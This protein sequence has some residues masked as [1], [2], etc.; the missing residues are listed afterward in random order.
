MAGR[1]TGMRSC[2]KAM[3][4][5]RRGLCRQARKSASAAMTSRT[6]ASKLPGRGWLEKPRR[7]I[8]RTCLGALSASASPVRTAAGSTS[9]SRGRRRDG[10]CS[11]R[12]Q[13]TRSSSATSAAVP[14]NC[15]RIRKAHESRSP[16]STLPFGRIILERLQ[17]EPDG[18]GP[19]RATASIFPAAGWNGAGRWRARGFPPRRDRSFARPAW[20]GQHVRRFGA[21]VADPGLRYGTAAGMVV[22]SISSAG[23]SARSGACA[24]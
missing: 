4:G 19:R 3:L 13:I 24:S 15:L 21:G 22:S 2:W 14:S 16:R 17:R 20:V 23:A 12:P 9:A 11:Y 7:R 8:P 10:R 1:R 6:T 18:A 5:V